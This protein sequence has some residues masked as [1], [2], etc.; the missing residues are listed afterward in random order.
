MR[1]KFLIFVSKMSASP[2]VSLMVD[3]SNIHG[4][5]EDVAISYPWLCLDKRSSK[6]EV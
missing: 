3:Q 4:L 1:D 5:P 2:L 6:S